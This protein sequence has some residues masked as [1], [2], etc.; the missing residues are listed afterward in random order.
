MYKKTDLEGFL[1]IVSRVAK[2]KVGENSIYLKRY[3]DMIN[4]SVLL[5][6]QQLEMI[7]CDRAEFEVTDSFEEG[8]ITVHLTYNNK[9]ITLKATKETTIQELFDQIAAQLNIDMKNHRLKGKNRDFDILDRK[10]LLSTYYDDMVVD[11]E[12]RELEKKAHEVDI[13]KISD[14]YDKSKRRETFTLQTDNPPTAD[15]IINFIETKFG[16]PESSLSI[17][18]LNGLEDPTKRI[19]LKGLNLKSLEIEGKIK[20]MVKDSP[21]MLSFELQQF[22]V[23]I[24]NSYP[25]DIER[26]FDISV[27]LEDCIA[28][29]KI[30]ILFKMVDLGV[31]KDE[32][33]NKFN[34]QVLN[35]Y[36]VPGKYLLNDAGL[37]KKTLF[38]SRKLLVRPKTG[39]VDVMSN[40]IC[41]FV[42][43]RN[44]IKRTYEHP[45][46]VL[47]TDK[48]RNINPKNIEAFK[49]AIFN[50]AGVS[51]A[52]RQ[53]AQLAFLDY[54]AYKWT[55]VNERPIKIKDGDDLSIIYNYPEQPDD[56]QTDEL[57][58]MKPS[59]YNFEGSKGYKEKAFKL[60]HG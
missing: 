16:M 8:T 9:V 32:E 3:G 44:R 13:I 27:A 60:T 36:N 55:L 12:V 1:S 25:Y 23:F 59:N 30:K 49:S 47:L 18:K 50:K 5:E 2:R 58:A 57:L 15:D 37:I 45:V 24:S 11:F 17:Y 56:L 20:V 53:T 39:D 35:T 41:L 28:D 51:E 52:D 7:L 40:E 54:K 19:K 42:R 14:D 31:F 10:E 46:E 33:I 22:T 26:K 6:K 4:L 21:N 48:F 38:Q 43:T 34:F 29:L